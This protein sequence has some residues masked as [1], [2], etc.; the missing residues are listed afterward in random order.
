MFE[1][2][3]GPRRIAIPHDDGEVRIP[4][5]GVRDGQVVCFYDVR[6]APAGGN[7]RAFTGE[8]MA[9]DLPNPNYLAYVVLGCELTPERFVQTP[10][11]SSDAAVASNEEQITVAY[12]SVDG[13]VSYMSSTFAGSHLVPWIGFART[14]E[15]FT[16][17]RLDVLY[18]ETQADGLF[19]TS[20]STI[21]FG[22][23]ALVPYVVR[24]G[25][26]AHVRVVHIRNGEYVRMSAPIASPNIQ[27]DET[28]LALDDNNRI[29]L[30]ARV[31]GFE[32]RGAGGRLV[33]VST[34]GLEFSPLEYR[35]MSDPGCNA[36]AL[37]NLLIH[38]HSLT[39]R[40]AGAIVDMTSGEVVYRFDD[41][42]FGYSDAIWHDNQLI[43]VAE[44]NN[45]LWQWTLTLSRSV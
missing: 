24:R 45:E 16:H 6:P 13:E 11:I 8:V 43:V 29:I 19:A 7:G 32:G 20:G 18:D 1:L 40:E 33:A 9:S 12:S 36:K 23:H 10:A 35:G 41:G 5:L 44:R 15:E 2:I 14:D 34:D 28:S 25:D 27:I 4:A 39:A 26:Q 42:E 31:Q 38:P 22:E 30:N 3:S 37:G 21:M 17:R